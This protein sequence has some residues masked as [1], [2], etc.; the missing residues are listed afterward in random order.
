MLP[1]VQVPPNAAS[2]IAE[3]DDILGGG[4]SRESV[5]LIEGKPGTGSR[6]RAAIPDGGRGGG[7][8]ARPSYHPLYSETEKELRQG[9][10]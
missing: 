10:A 7:G 6:H 4:F 5:F 2:G 9:A 3:L 1:D 8:R